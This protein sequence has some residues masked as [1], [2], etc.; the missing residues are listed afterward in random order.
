MSAPVLAVEMRRACG[1]G[2]LS[3][4]VGFHD[5]RV[6]SRNAHHQG[7]RAEEPVHTSL[8]SCSLGHVEHIPQLKEP[9]EMDLFPVLSTRMISCWKMSSLFFVF[10][11]APFWM[12]F[13]FVIV[14]LLVVVMCVLPAPTGHNAH[15]TDD[16]MLGVAPV[17]SLIAMA[18]MAM[19][20]T[21]SLRFPQP[22][23][24]LGGFPRLSRLI[25]LPLLACSCAHQSRP[26]RR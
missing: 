8:C 2:P 14:I 26:L 23:I 3:C 15:H 1:P 5:L 13:L 25:Q 18:V 22:P 12:T 10:R 7:Q 24:A 4:R 17:L 11:K 19:V 9:A 21:V 6:M 20:S 16:H